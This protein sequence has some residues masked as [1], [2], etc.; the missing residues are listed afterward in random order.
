M[1]GC[2]F[3]VWEKVPRTEGHEVPILLSPDQRWSGAFFFLAN[4]P[5]PGSVADAGPHDAGAEGRATPVEHLPAVPGWI[6]DTK[7]FDSLFSLVPNCLMCCA[8]DLC[9]ALEVNA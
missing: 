5:G 4:R 9:S 2:G 7:Y 6:P 1:H 3:G 8:Q